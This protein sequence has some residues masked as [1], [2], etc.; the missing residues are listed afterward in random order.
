MNGDLLQR[1]RYFFSFHDH[2]IS[3]T[4]EEIFEIFI[5]QWLAMIIGFTDLI[6]YQRSIPHNIKGDQEILDLFIRYCPHE[7]K[8]I[9]DSLSAIEISENKRYLA[10]RKSKR[11]KDSIVEGSR[12]Q[13]KSLAYSWLNGRSDVKEFENFLVVSRI[14][15]NNLFHGKKS[16]ID[17]SDLELIRNVTPILNVINM[18]IR[19]LLH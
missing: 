9:S 14:V 12:E 2:A 1:S 19:G 18:Q 5:F 16:F 8:Q 15:R 11:S 7:S 10:R 3:K 13:G 6:S 4:D 17:D